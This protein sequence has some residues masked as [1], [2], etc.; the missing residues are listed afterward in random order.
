[1][2][3]GSDPWWGFRGQ[4]L[5]HFWLFTVIKAIKRL[6]IALK[7]LYSWPEKLYQFITNLFVVANI[8]ISAEYN[9]T[10]RR[11]SHP[12][13]FV[14]GRLA[15]GRDI[16]RCNITFALRYTPTKHKKTSLY[17]AAPIGGTSCFFSLKIKH[18]DLII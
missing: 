8:P 1:M 3:S 16:Y 9:I 12:V 18:Q 4:S 14:G 17:G 2:G 5:K 6:A 15:L 13:A 11:I 7:K 10:Q